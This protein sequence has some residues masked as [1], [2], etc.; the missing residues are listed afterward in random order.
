MVFDS[1]FCV[2]S[3]DVM[4]CW[5]SSFVPWVRPYQSRALPPFVL[6]CRPRSSILHFRP[7]MFRSRPSTL[8]FAVVADGVLSL[9]VTVFGLSAPNGWVGCWLKCVLTLCCSG[10][11]YPHNGRFDILIAA[12]YD[13]TERGFGSGLWRFKVKNLTRTAKKEH[14]GSKVAHKDKGTYHHI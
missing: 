11:W 5:R 4:Y 3:Q 9:A 12:M 6:I 10:G 13:S 8:R 1:L 2:Q 14:H 7:S